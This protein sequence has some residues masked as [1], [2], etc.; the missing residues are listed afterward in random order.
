MKR[1]NAA[2]YIPVLAAQDMAVFS[3]VRGVAIWVGVLQALIQSP[4][5]ISRRENYIGDIKTY[6]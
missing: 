1:S 3:G 4:N 5:C 2:Y 6:Q